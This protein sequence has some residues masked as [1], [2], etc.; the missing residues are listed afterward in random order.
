MRR[1]VIERR[2]H[3]EG[4][5]ADRQV[6]PEDDRPVGMLDQE[7]AERRPDDGG[8]AEDAREEALHPGAL[9]RRVDV[10][11]DGVGHRL[12]GAGTD[13]LQRA[14]GDQRQHALRE[15]AQRR[16]HQEHARAHE[17][18]ALAAVEI[19]QPPVDRDAHRLRQ[20]IGGEHPAEEMEVAE[21]GNDRGHRGR[22][23]RGFHGRHEGRHHAGRQ[24]QAA[25]SRSRLR[26]LVLSAFVRHA[27]R[28]GHPA[29]S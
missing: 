17:E 3:G 24:D 16:A 2:Q 7:G 21:V 15:A 28:F 6:D 22:H 4:E 29:R 18:N 8:E 9:G 25:T 12:H 19:G 26:H 10:A 14:E 20:Q 1:L 5:R 27:T 11:D 23:D 13:A